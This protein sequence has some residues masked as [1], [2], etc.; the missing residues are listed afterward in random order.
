MG[1]CGVGNYVFCRYRGKEREG[2]REREYMQCPLSAQRLPSRA[3][4]TTLTHRGAGREWGVDGGRRSRV[5]ILVM[6]GEG[7]GR[8]GNAGRMDFLSDM[9]PSASRVG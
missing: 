2:G 1:G 5:R 4:Q 3:V 7:E 9:P 6:G 8:G